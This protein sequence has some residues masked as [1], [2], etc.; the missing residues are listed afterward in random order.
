MKKYI[1]LLFLSIGIFFSCNSD[2]DYQNTDSQAPSAP[3]NLV[4][5]NVTDTAISLNWDAATDNTGVTGYKIYQDGVEVNT[6]T[7]TSATINNLTSGVT[8]LF[9]VT[10]Y[11]LEENE[12]SPSNNLEIATA[13]IFKQSLQEMGF[14]SGNISFLQPAQGVVLYD[15]NSRLFTDYAHK[16][17]LLKLPEG[18][19]MDYNNSNLLPN[20]PD[21]TLI[22]KTFYY[23]NDETNPSLGKQ[24]IETRVLLKVNGAWKLGNYVWNASQT[25]AVL[26][27]SGS[28]IPINY[29]DANG[30]AQAINY[31]IPSQDN[32]ITCHSTNNIQTPIGLKLRNLNFNPQNGTVNQ[33]QL[34]YLLD[35]GLLRG[36]ASPSD[37]SVLPDWTD[38]SSYTILERGRAYMEIN[39]AHCHQPG[40]IVPPGFLLDFRLETPFETTGIYSH[41]GQIE[42]RIQSTVPTYRMPQLGRTVVH[43][44]GVAMMLEYLQAIE[45]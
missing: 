32:C 26:T 38:D 45:E 7:T 17:R 9:Y 43:T 1:L 5:T 25:D 44:E 16:Q 15:L 13:L 21:N 41:R 35:N 19:F 42:D 12:S 2:D 40:G 27:D 18:K 22:A 30:N 6:T 8:Y 20:F 24:I 28:I 34:Q 4:A 37:I 14:F 23:Y 33:N 36:L 31:E 39:C 3:L 10:A 29:T 11:D